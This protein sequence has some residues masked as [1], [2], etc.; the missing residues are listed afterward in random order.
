[1][2]TDPVACVWARA[3]ARENTR[4]KTTT[5]MRKE[6]IGHSLQNCSEPGLEADW[7]STSATVGQ[8][9]SDK[10]EYYVWQCCWKELLSGSNKKTVNSEVFHLGSVAQQTLRV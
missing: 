7:C 3:A 6:R 2:V 9:L 1:M 8:V 4:E 5:K 10:R